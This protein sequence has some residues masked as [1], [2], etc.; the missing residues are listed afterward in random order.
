[1]L[2]GSNKTVQ[3]FT[4]PTESSEED[5]ALF[6]EDS[7]VFDQS[8]AVLAMKLHSNVQKVRYNGDKW[9]LGISDDEHVTIY[10]SENEMSLSCKPGHVG[11][12][13]KSAQVDPTGQYVATTGTDGYL[14]VYK[15]D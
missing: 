7:T 13:A 8:N 2:G 14:N 15:I 3:I 12:Q 5:A 1:M 6:K 9:V 4:L 11:C 10:N